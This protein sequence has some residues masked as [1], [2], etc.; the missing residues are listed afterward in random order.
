MPSLHFEFMISY[1]FL[2]DTEH[3]ISIP[4]GE[5]DYKLLEAERLHE[6]QFILVFPRGE[7][8]AARMLNGNGAYGPSYQ[9]R[10][11]GDNR[12]VPSYLHEGAHV[13]VLLA[14]MGDKNHAI[15]VALPREGAGWGKI[16]WWTMVFFVV[17]WLVHSYVWHNQLTYDLYES[18]RCAYD[19][20][21][22]ACQMLERPRYPFGG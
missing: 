19:N 14:K 9:L 6:G 15:L 12:N 22:E 10:L 2:R 7:R 11:T 20:R 13:Y 16:V 18:L 4:P 5:V 3:R 21:S 8:T 17:G 1:S